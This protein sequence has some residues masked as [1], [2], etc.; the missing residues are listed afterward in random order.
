MQEDENKIILKKKR[1]KRNLF[2]DW[3]LVKEKRKKKIYI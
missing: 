3:K 1:R 2:I